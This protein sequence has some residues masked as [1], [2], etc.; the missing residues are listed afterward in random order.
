[1][2]V[3]FATRTASRPAKAVI[4]AA[5]LAAALIAAVPAAFVVGLVL[6]ILGHVL[7]GLA[8]FGA[9]VLAAL[10]AVVLAGLSGAR[11]LRRLA[12]RVQAQ[13]QA[14]DGPDIR[15]VRLDQSEYDSRLT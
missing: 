11:Y 13:V 3:W 10:A 8:L 5:V 12:G 1:M 6:M 15:V 14:D 4:A 9:S 7:I 2:A